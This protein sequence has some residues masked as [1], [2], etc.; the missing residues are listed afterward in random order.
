MKRSFPLTLFCVALMSATAFANHL[1][2][3]PNCCGDNFADISTVNG[4]PLVLLGGT[5]P[6]F[7]SSEGYAPGSALGGGGSLYLYSTVIWI[8]GVPVEF[9]FPPGSIFMT[10]FTLPANGAGFKV[11]VEISYFIS[12]INYDTGQTIDLNG[13]AGGS[14]S[15][16]FSDATGLYYADQFVQA[17]E[18]GTLG[19]LAIGLVAVMALSRKRLRVGLRASV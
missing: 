13:G 17:P 11:L 8:G 18:P 12:G 19:L 5:D 6:S 9:F 3:A 15:F 16:Y 7:L 4:H 14:I 2:L 10:P 1:Y